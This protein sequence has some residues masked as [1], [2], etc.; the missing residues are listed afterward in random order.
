MGAEEVEAGLP[1]AV[2]VAS[3]AVCLAGTP[4]R[5]RLPSFA[6]S[7]RLA[8]GLPQARRQHS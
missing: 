3:S 7:P 5:A 2:E 4:L 6:L 8:P 1:R